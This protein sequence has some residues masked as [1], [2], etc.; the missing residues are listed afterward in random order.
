MCYQINSLLKSRWTLLGEGRGLRA[1]GTRLQLECQ[2][3]IAKSV[4][5]PG[6]R[7]AGAR[8]PRRSTRATRCA[9]AAT[10]RSARRARGRSP[11]TQASTSRES[12]HSIIHYSTVLALQ[13]RGASKKS[14]EQSQYQGSEAI[15]DSQVLS[16]DQNINILERA[17]LLEQTGDRI[18]VVV[19]ARHLTHSG[20]TNYYND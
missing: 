15:C 12:L 8:A 6:W 11:S 5:V 4:L 13:R 17:N 20:S 10:A 16:F 7:W 18:D 9:R 3:P 1:E 2:E 19:S 14:A